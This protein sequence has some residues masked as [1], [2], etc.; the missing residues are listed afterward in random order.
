MHEDGLISIRYFKKYLW[1]AWRSYLV[2]V[3]IFI[4]Y[5]IVQVFHFLL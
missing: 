4:V 1:S 3:V 2:F 5:F